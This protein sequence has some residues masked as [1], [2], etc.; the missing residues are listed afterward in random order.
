MFVSGQPV[1][2]CG[3]CRRELPLDAFNRMGEGRQ[4]WCRECFR[5]YFRERG[6]VHRRQVAERQRR[7]SE[8]ARAVVVDHLARHPCVDCGERDVAVLEFDHVEAKTQDVAFLISHGASPERLSEEIARCE[9]RCAN[10]HRRVTAHRSGWIRATGRLDDPAIG[11][12]A[13][14]RRNVRH[15]FAALASGCVDCGEQDILVLEFDHVGDKRST[16]TSLAWSETSLAR[17]DAEIACCE[18]RC[19]NCHRRR[20]A[21]ARRRRARA[22]T[23]ADGPSERAPPTTLSRTR[24]D[25]RPVSA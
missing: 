1:K 3:R 24:L 10:C 19:C 6:D 18:V 12:S 8:A 15:M 2:T 13:T 25:G 7:I 11:L 23:G 16:V 9:V 20:T 17:I 21:A 22:P 14:K 5:A 4:H